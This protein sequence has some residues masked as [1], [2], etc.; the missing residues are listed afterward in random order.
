MTAK[1]QK[2][3][4]EYCKTLNAT[5]ALAWTGTLVN[6]F[7]GLAAKPTN[8]VDVKLLNPTNRCQFS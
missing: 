3:V 4:D 7:A 1:Q 8:T 6:C 5:D 2:F